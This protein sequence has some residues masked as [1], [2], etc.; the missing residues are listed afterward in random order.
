MFQWELWRKPNAFCFNYLCHSNEHLRMFVNYCDKVF[1]L[2]N[3]FWILFLINSRFV[4]R[5]K[6]VRE[7][8]H[9][10]T[11]THRHSS[12]NGSRQRNWKINRRNL[13]EAIFID[14]V[15]FSWSFTYHIFWNGWI[16]FYF[17]IEKKY[18]HRVLFSFLGGFWLQD[19]VKCYH[20][21]ITHSHNNIQLIRHPWL[22]LYCPCQLCSLSFLQIR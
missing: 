7:R 20:Y 13:Y 3:M 21:R 10:N 6:S 18:E 4:A 19:V 8:W 2:E 22:W 1:Y 11:H 17:I 14:A 16:N 15:L 12:K 9:Q 5:I